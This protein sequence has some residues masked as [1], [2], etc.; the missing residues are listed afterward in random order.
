[1][2]TFTVFFMMF[3]GLALVS[4]IAVPVF[5]SGKTDSPED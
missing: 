2:F 5:C 3:A 4:A 1:M